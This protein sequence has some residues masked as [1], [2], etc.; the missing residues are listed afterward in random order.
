MISIE[1]LNLTIGPD[2][3][4]TQAVVSYDLRGGFTQAGV[5]TRFTELVDLM[6]DDSRPGEDGLDD[7]IPN[8][9]RLNILLLPLADPRRVHVFN[10][11]PGALD[12]DPSANP[13]AL[14]FLQ[15]EIF[16]R[17]TVSPFQ[18][19]VTARSNVVIRGGPILARRSRS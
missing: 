5:L 13:H 8:G 3:D 17:V 7:F 6:G 14:S 4:F 1:N 18:T 12:E 15:D 16:A 19:P 2:H 11:A 10:L 9:R